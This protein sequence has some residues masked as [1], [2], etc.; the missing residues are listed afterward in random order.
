MTVSLSG[1][2]LYLVPNSHSPIY[3]PA[4]PLGD[5]PGSVTIPEGVLF[6][7]DFDYVVNRAAAANDAD[8]PVIFTTTGPWE[9]YKDLRTSN[10]GAG[11]YLYTVDA[12][13]GYS[14]VIPGNSGRM[15]CVECLAE[16]VAPYSVPPNIRETDFYLQLGQEAGADGFIPADVW[17]QYWLYTSDSAAVSQESRFDNGSKWL[18]PSRNAYP[19]T[20]FSWL[21]SRS[22]RSGEKG[23]GTTWATVD[24]ATGDSYPIVYSET[25]DA[26]PFGEAPEHLGRNESLQVIPTNQFVLVKVHLNTS[27]LQ[28]VFEEW[29]RPLGGNW[30]KTAE[31]VGGTGPGS[32]TWPLDAS[33][34]LGHKC[35]RFPTTMRWRDYGGGDIRGGDSW[36]YLAD[37]AMAGSEANL[38][39]YSGY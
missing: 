15:L 36:S 19:S 38:P 10:P 28:G 17:F 20:D 3:D 37:F 12:I 23:D 8:G 27:G 9:S 32:F 13:P 29:Q 31:W 26:N 25:A 16:S 7:D 30:T 24:T 4:Y 5:R 21:L 22:A 14:G 1:R 39:T 18:Y 35:L 11:G 33:D 2:T 6:F 34:N